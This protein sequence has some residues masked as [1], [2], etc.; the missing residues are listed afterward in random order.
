M[1][2]GFMNRYKGKQSFPIGGIWIAG[3][4]VNASGA[5]FNSM[6]GQGSTSAASLTPA[7]NSTMNGSGVSNIISATAASVYTLAAPIGPGVEKTIALT[8]V[9]SGVK[10][11]AA[12]GTNFG[13]TAA[14]STTTVIGSTTLMNIALESIST[15]SW[16][17]VAAW[18]GSTATIATP[19]LTTTT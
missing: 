18:T 4:Q 1:P 19:T 5:D 2:T 6:L 10:I 9:S 12:A 15:L 8:Q 7:A 3:T 14:G 13:V 16:A 17:I 11:K